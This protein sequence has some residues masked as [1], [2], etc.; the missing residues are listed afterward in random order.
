MSE[1]KICKMCKEEWPADAQF[2]FRDKNYKDGFSLY[3]KACFH[4]M[5]S[6]KRKAER[7]GGQRPLYSD[8]EQLFPEYQER[9]A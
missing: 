1:E 9:R 2:F 3:C 5:P 6:G 7:R 8:W 4:D